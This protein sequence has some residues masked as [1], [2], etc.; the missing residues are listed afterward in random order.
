MFSADDVYDSEDA[1][2]RAAGYLQNR[3]M[4]YQT[5]AVKC[6]GNRHIFPGMRV[7]I[8]YVGDYFSGEYIAERVVHELSVSRGFMTE[9]YVKRNMTAGEQV[10]YPGLSLQS[11]KVRAILRRSRQPG[12][13]EMSAQPCMRRKQM[14]QS[15]MRSSRLLHS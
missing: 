12:E 6:E 3:S 4:E 5:G 13:K 2:Q 1:K 11:R 9:V 10:M 7:E 15:L 8:K 14:I